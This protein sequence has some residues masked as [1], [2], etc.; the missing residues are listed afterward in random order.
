MLSM[1]RCTCHKSL[2]Q[3]PIT[4]RWNKAKFSTSSRSLYDHILVNRPAKG[5]SLV[6][7]NRP[8]SL[9][10]LFTP[11]ILELNDA[12]QSADSDSSIGA[13]VITGSER[14]FAAGAD[15]KEMKDKTF[16]EVYEQ[17]FIRNWSEATRV[18]KPILAAV[19]GYALGGGCELAMMADIIY[20]GEKAVFGQPEIKLGIIPGAGGTQRLTRL[21]GKSR[22][23]ELILTGKTLNAEQALAWGLVSAI[24]PPDKLVEET[25]NTATLIASHGR[26][27]VQ[28]AKESINYG[29]QVGLEDGLLYE[30]KL[31]YSLFATHDQKEGMSAFIE[32]RPSK[33]KGN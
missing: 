27:A 24:Y 23:T 12:L 15:I 3:L 33:F 22:A 11:L 16:S 32:K 19:N 10:A 20:A 31:F 25:I 21:I 9:N 28:A 17:N 18:K 26:L 7:L 14:A 8:K 1:F 5:V 6:T 2:N 4:N 29:L 13:I 30:R